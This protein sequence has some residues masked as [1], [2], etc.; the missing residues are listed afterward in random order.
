MHVDDTAMSIE[1]LHYDDDDTNEGSSRSAK[2]PPKLQRILTSFRQPFKTT[3]NRQPSQ[4]RHGFISKLFQ[5][6]QL[7]PAPDRPDLP[8]SPM[9]APPFDKIVDGNRLS[10]QFSLDP[11][12]IQKNY[13]LRATLLLSSARDARFSGL[14]FNI[15]MDDGTILAISHEN[16]LGLETEAEVTRDRNYRASLRKSYQTLTGGAPLSPSSIAS[17]ITLAEHI[18]FIRNTRGTIQGSGVGSSKACWVIKEDDGSRAEQGLGPVFDLMVKLD[19]RPAIISFEVEAYILS[20][21]GKRKTIQSGILGA[22]V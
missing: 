12:D 1:E 18:T 7:P 13:T 22:S 14:T 15:D 11:K 16:V 17:T 20:E 3:S 2:A 6:E 5:S 9:P 19:V 21:S 8:P 10:V 4:R